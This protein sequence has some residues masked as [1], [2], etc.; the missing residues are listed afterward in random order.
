MIGKRADGGNRGLCRGARHDA[1]PTGADATLLL[2]VADA[3]RAQERSTPGGVTAP[4]AFSARARPLGQVAAR[5]QS[6][7]RFVGNALWSDAT[8]RARAGELVLPAH[9]LTSNT[10]RRQAEFPTAEGA[11]VCCQPAAEKPPMNR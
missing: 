1:W 6:L 9:A 2:G 10:D 4:W 11:M 7:L 3:E 5:G 8:I